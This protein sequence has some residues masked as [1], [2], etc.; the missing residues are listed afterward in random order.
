MVVVVMVVAL[1]V[2]LVLL[3]VERM[4]YGKNEKEGETVISQVKMSL[5]LQ[6]QTSL[7]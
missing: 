1:A 2:V 7:S 4:I 5:E 6:V 3:V